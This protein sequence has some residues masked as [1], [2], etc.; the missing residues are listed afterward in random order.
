MKNRLFRR[1]GSN[2]PTTIGAEDPPARQYASAV[3]KNVTHGVR[4][5]GEFIGNHPLLCLGAALAVGMIAGWRVKR[6]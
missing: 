2:V 6:S 4:S 5:A 3:R 1:D